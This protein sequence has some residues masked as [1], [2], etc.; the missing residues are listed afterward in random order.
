[1]SCS[2]PYCRKGEWRNYEMGNKFIIIPLLLWAC[3]VLVLYCA[4]FLPTELV[5]KTD[6]NTLKR[7]E[8]E[9]IQADGRSRQSS[10]DFYT[11]LNL[12]QEQRIVIKRLFPERLVLR[13]V[14]ESAAVSIRSIELIRLG[15]FRRSFEGTLNLSCSGGSLFF[16]VPVAVLLLLF[17]GGCAGHVYFEC[18]C[19]WLERLFR[20]RRMVFWTSAFLLMYFFLTNLLMYFQNPGDDWKFQCLGAYGFSA[21]PEVIRMRWDTWGARVLF[22]AFLSV[23]CHASPLYFFCGVMVVFSGI[24]FFLSRLMRKRSEKQELLP[25]GI[26][27]LLFPLN[28]LV[29]SGWQATMVNY[30]LPLFLLFPFLFCIRDVFD[31]K[32]TSISLGMTG[33]VCALFLCNSELVCLSIVLL[34]GAVLVYCPVCRVKPSIWIP[35]NLLVGL[36]SLCYIFLCPGNAV[37]SAVEI[38]RGVSGIR[39]LTLIQKGMLGVYSSLFYLNHCNMLWMLLLILTAVAV[40]LEWKNPV[41][42]L[43]ASFPL[44]VVLLSMNMPADLLDERLIAQ[45]ADPLHSGSFLMLAGMESL[46]LVS[47]LVS[48]VLSRRALLPG[49]ILAGG[50]LIALATRM[51]TGMT[52]VVYT[53][54]ERTYVFCYFGFLLLCVFLFDRIS[55]AL[56]RENRRAF[57]LIVTVFALVLALKVFCVGILNCVRFAF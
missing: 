28:V 31:G 27:C 36:G 50:V 42:R 57:F 21:L 22:D 56:S 40:W 29:T 32:Q 38:S 19:H 51:A 33:L 43:I 7:L 8:V 47:L 46:S 39:D 25:V 3:A 18:R 44:M 55:M 53:S 45:I 20:R 30:A 5:L 15:V 34:S 41:T 12:P 14:P 6:S 54:G 16:S 48:L 24:V 17:V 4:F 26:L 52:P 23:S 37:R 2:P 10:F 13:T 35:A 11:P 9:W 49:C 1:M